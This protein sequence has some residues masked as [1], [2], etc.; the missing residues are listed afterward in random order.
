MKRCVACGQGFQDRFNF[1]PVDGAALVLSSRPTTLEYRPTIISEKALAHRLAFQIVFLVERAKV[2]W[3]RFRSNPRAFL[4][5]SLSELV[6]VV[7]LA[8]A[9]PYLPTG[10]LAALTILV[11]ITS[12][13]I[14]LERRVAKLTDRD[15]EAVDPTQVT[16]IDSSTTPRDSQTGIGASE[17]EHGRVGFAKGRGEGSGPTPARAQGGG[18]GGNNSSLPASQGRLPI[19]S[20]IPAPISNTYA[21]L[22]A[23]PD[24]GI[25]LDPV[26]WKD[27]PF[28]NYGDPRSKSTNTSNGPGTGGGVGTGQGTGIG[29]GTGPGV[30]PGNDGNTGGGNNARGCCGSSGANGDNTSKDIDRV[31]RQT[32]VSARARVISKP[33]PQYT[34]EARR[35]QITGRVVLSVVFDRTGQVTNIRAVQTLCCGLTEKAIAAARQ[36][37]FVPAMRDG[38]VVSTYMQLEY[39]FNLY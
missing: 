30:G 27:L 35:N 7:R 17:G 25:N 19:P 3:P 23:L 14:L 37:R 21:R 18:G 24:A 29:K 16:L 12:S 8:F 32:E 10:L 39:N 34:E 2:A 4:N 31:F 20:D 33:E 22:P 15:D 11:C 26:L 9:R 36:I 6:Q 13:V 5:E 28:P 38:L 1:C